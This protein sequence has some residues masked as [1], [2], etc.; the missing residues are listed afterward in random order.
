MSAWVIA[1]IVIGV[2]IAV[3]MEIGNLV[4]AVWFIILEWRRAKARD[5]WWRKNNCK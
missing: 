5:W 2:I 4:L 3:I 1:A